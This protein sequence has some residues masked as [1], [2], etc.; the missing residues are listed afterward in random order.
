[1][2]VYKRSILPPRPYLHRNWIR[3]VNRSEIMGS[4]S[5]KA[6]NGGDAGHGNDGDA[7]PAKRQRCD[8]HVAVPQR[9]AQKDL[10][11]L[12]LPREPDQTDRKMRVEL[13]NISPKSSR[14]HSG[15][16]L[17]LP[18]AP[19]LHDVSS[20]EARCRITV[21]S[22]TAGAAP[23][24]LYADSQSCTLRTFM[25][26]SGSGFV[27][28]IEQRAPFYVDEDKLL[29]EQ[30]GLEGYAL[31]SA[32]IVRVVLESAGS[33]EWLPAHLAAAVDEEGNSHNDHKERR[34][35]I[36]SA[37]VRDCTKCSNAPLKL[38]NGLHNDISTDYAIAVDIRWATGCYA[39]KRHKAPKIPLVTSV[40]ADALVH[41]PVVVGTSDGQNT[42]GLA[43]GRASP[44]ADAPVDGYLDGFAAGDDVVVD[45][46]LTPNQRSLRERSDRDY[47]VKRLFHKALGRGPR[48][49]RKQQ[50]E[51][52]P[53]DFTEMTYKTVGAA[54]LV[55]EGFTCC[56]C[57]AR[58]QTFGQLQAHVLC[59][60]DFDFQFGADP[61]AGAFAD[62]Q[63]DPAS[64]GSLLRPGIYQLGKPLG[65]FNLKKY[66]GGEES[67]ITARLGPLNY[68]PEKEQ[69]APKQGPVWSTLPLTVRPGL[70]T[71][72][73]SG[74]F[75]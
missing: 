7:R 33:N 2:A 69:Q 56:V 53:L 25:E 23:Q 72:G 52:K 40:D 21:S 13:L 9:Q 5:S 36:L 47:N 28:R 59:H 63:G 39:W 73:Q 45:G 58:N 26:G 38:S 61:K 18:T 70:V 50:G 55:L 16:L 30:E 67:W 19:L 20:T 37:V 71:S 75:R 60:T 27:T 41:D 3:A 42:D 66:I 24:V 32:Y 62:V 64:P 54:S 74:R 57:G 34:Q 11:Q 14:S 68:L 15:L 43:N 10:A 49:P 65:P 48:S 1:M 29:R 51:L 12:V 8:G 46:E 31:P 22:R 6:R 4:Q 44:T 35:W 17:G